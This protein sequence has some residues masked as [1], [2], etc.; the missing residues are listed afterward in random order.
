[1][2]KLWMVLGLYWMSFGGACLAT[3]LAFGGSR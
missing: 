3:F 1:M 2:N